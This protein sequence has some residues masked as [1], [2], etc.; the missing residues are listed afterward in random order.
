MVQFSVRGKLKLRYIGPYEVLERIR[1]VT[2]QLALPLSLVGIHNVFH[3]LQ[4]K[5]CLSDADTMI[6]THQPE[7]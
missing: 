6:D 4:L 2:Y 7:V 3:M 5:K 1:L